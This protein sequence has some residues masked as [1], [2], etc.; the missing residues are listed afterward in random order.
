MD[1]TPD[2][3]KQML[4][5]SAGV[6][7][8]N[9]SVEDRRAGML[10]ATEPMR[11][12]DDVGIETIDLGGV[13]GLKLTPKGAKAT[14][15][16]L[17]FHGGGYVIGSSETHKG[18]VS[19]IAD[20][21]GAPSYSMDYRMGP[22]APFPAAVDDGVA[23][24]R[25]LLE[26]FPAGQIVIGGDSAGG[27]LT[28]AVAM[29]ARDTGLEMP[30]GLMVLSPWANL[31]QIGASYDT[32]AEDDPMVSRDSLAWFA[33]TYLGGSANADDPYASP[34]YGDFTGLPPILIQV[35]A[36]EVL[37]SDSL[38]IAEKA[39]TQNVSVTLEIFPEMLHVFQAFYPFLGEARSAIQTLGQWGAAKTAS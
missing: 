24:Y 39:G 32:K 13:A 34:V 21:M 11:P 26:Q 19:Y 12:H 20:A 17:Y 31:N 2:Q 27:G 5:A 18:L 7:S 16:L 37:L 3:I 6:T 29:K 1:M 14:A 35:G 22:E 28:L 10:A 33:D 38:A 9:A 30:A 25:A 4:K 15:A 23:A 8:A 36:D